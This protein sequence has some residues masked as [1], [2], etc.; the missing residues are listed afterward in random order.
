M[1][2]VSNLH[3]KTKIESRPRREIPLNIPLFEGG[4]VTSSF[5]CV[6]PMGPGRARVSRNA[7]GWPK[8]FFTQFFP[9]TGPLASLVQKQFPAAPHAAM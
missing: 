9:S 3:K 4:L 5:I 7:D 6:D 1:I 2:D 8:P